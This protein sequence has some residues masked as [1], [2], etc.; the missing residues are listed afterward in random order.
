MPAPPLKHLEVTT[1]TGVARLGDARPAA[2]AY[3]IA[4]LVDPAPLDEI[5]VTAVN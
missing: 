2:R 4:G 5:S 1:H 3:V